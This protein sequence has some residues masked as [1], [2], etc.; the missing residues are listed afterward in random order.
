MVVVN[1]TDTLLVRE[2]SMLVKIT[3]LITMRSQPIVL[4]LF[5]LFV[6]VVV[7]VDVV[8]VPDVDIVVYVTFKVYL[9]LLEMKVEFWWVWLGG[10]WWQVVVVCPPI[11]MSNPTQMSWKGHLPCTV[12]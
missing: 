8:F 5:C 4:R 10:G 1:P 7:V 9:R 2:T 3:R 12:R 6:V 11:F